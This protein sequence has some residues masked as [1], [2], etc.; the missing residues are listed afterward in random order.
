MHEE[1]CLNFLCVDP[2][3]Y[4]RRHHIYIPTLQS[5]YLIS[6]SDYLHSGKTLS[7]AVPFLV[8]TLFTVSHISVDC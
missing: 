2:R 3:L 7:K 1:K 5:I 8:A 6:D 4:C